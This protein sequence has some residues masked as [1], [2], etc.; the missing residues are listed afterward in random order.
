MENFQVPRI[1]V[2]GPSVDWLLRAV[3][4]SQSGNKWICRTLTA[5]GTP[6]IVR[7]IELIRVISIHDKAKADLPRVAQTS[8]ALG[9][10][11]CHRKGRQQHGSQNCNDRYHH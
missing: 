7:R 11:F 9:L 6:S 3:I 1:F 5:Y 8:Y 2:Q 10:L 4:K